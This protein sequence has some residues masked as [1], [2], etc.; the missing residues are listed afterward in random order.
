LDKKVLFLL[1]YVIYSAV[2]L[3]GGSYTFTKTY[4]R[5]PLDIGKLKAMYY[6]ISY[7][8]NKYNFLSLSGEIWNHCFRFLLTFCYLFG[9]WFY[10]PSIGSTT[11]VHHSPG[12]GTGKYWCWYILIP[13]LNT[14]AVSCYDIV[15]RL[16]ASRF[17]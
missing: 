14:L 6:S 7:F 1:S 12:P 11:K 9:W 4:W 5:S 17:N 15:L 3:F 16:S 10:N 13:N 8:H 2:D